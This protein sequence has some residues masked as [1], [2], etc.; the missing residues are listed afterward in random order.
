MRQGPRSSPP[1]NGG[2]FFRSSHVI[3]SSFAYPYSCRSAPASGL[4]LK[5]S[6]GAETVETDESGAW[7]AW[8]DV[9]KRLGNELVHC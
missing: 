3:D 5:S 8:E 2:L 9:G 4:L 7:S 6:E 1:N